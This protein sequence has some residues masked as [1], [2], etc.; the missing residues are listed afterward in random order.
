MSIA[1]LKYRRDKTS[2]DAVPCH[3]AN[4]SDII[5]GK[6]SSA[7]VW[8]AAPVVAL[9]P[10]MSNNLKICQR[11][12]KRIAVY[13]VNEVAVGYR[14]IERGMDKPMNEISLVLSATVVGDSFMLT[15]R[16]GKR[17]KNTSGLIVPLCRVQPNS[18]NVRDIP[19]GNRL[20]LLPSFHF[21]Y[22]TAASKES[23][24]AVL[25]F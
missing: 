5:I 1:N 7:N 6:L 2:A 12:I 13:V 20:A 14:A 11:I 10:R 17:G 16:S 19:V 9:V 25:P 15:A 24:N 21:G 23:S 3:S 4:L 8:L 22:D 18:S